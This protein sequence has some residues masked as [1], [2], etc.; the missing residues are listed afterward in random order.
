MHESQIPCQAKVVSLDENTQPVSGSHPNINS[1]GTRDPSRGREVTH[2]L[3][4]SDE[5]TNEWSYAS[6][7]LMI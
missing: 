5:I 6:K 2:S 7:P 4:A 3:L 1:T